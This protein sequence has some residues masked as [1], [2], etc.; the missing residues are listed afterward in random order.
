[1]GA[2]VTIHLFAVF[3]VEREHF[4]VAVLVNDSVHGSEFSVDTTYDCR[5]CKS[6][7]D[8]LCHVKRAH[9]AVK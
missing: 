2:S 3:V 5:S 9:R 7:A 8:V 6:F 4:K 1:M